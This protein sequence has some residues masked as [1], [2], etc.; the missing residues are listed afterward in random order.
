MRNPGCHTRPRPIYKHLDSYQNSQRHASYGVK[1]NFRDVIS[2]AVY[3]E[4]V[5][6]DLP[7]SVN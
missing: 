7:A 5:A 3:R 1:C 2:I 4:Q 6:F